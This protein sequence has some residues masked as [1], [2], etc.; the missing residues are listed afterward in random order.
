MLVTQ[1]SKKV[2]E[3]KLKEAEFETGLE[4]L[5]NDDL[6]VEIFE[7][8]SEYLSPNLLSSTKKQREKIDRIS[9]IIAKKS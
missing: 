9:T 7:T 4:I 1:R 8:I 5:A 2:T 6:P 3:E